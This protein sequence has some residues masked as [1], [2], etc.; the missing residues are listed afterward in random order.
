MSEFVKTIVSG[1]HQH[2]LR[3][4]A[5]AVTLIE[6][7]R[8]SDQSH[9]DALLSKIMPLTGNAVRIGISGIPGVGKKQNEI[10]RCNYTVAKATM[11]C[12]FVLESDKYKSKTVEFEC[13]TYVMA[14]ISVTYHCG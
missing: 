4:I 11:S 13:Q 5:K 12:D 6:S 1:I 9:A 8:P 3:A 10:R 14:F 7:T 2:E